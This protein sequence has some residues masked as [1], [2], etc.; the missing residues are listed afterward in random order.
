MYECQKA[1]LPRS[2]LNHYFNT[3]NIVKL[4]I[5]INKVL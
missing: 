1:L 4:C 3:F 5:K 2:L